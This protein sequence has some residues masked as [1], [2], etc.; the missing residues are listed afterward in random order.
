MRSTR[1]TSSLYPELPSRHLLTSICRGRE[2]ALR[3]RERESKREE[4]RERRFG[5]IVSRA[6]GCQPGRFARKMQEER[7]LA[8][9]VSRF[10][11]GDEEQRNVI[12]LR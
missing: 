2:T 8:G 4:E 7:G 11:R 10:D 5:N 9:G 12:P 3:K 6:F 1:E